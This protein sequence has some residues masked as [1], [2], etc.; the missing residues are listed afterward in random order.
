[1]FHLGSE[2]L[3]ETYQVIKITCFLVV[4]KII[5]KQNAVKKKHR[6]PSN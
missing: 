3:V 6:D 5:K 2:I 1:M 4:G